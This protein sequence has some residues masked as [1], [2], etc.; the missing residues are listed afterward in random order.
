[1]RR[2]PNRRRSSSSSIWR[3]VEARRVKDEFLTN[4]THELRTPLTAVMGYISL[5]QEEF[6]G[7]LTDHQR[8]DLALARDASDRLL[9]LIDNLL[10]MTT[11]KRE[12]DGGA[13]RD[14]RSARPAARCR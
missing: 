6:S 10:E 11:L 12:R 7:P 14:L 1:M 2:S 8:N 4:V 9:A 5:L 13:G 3:F